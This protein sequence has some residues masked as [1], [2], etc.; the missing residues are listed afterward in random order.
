V[1]RRIAHGKCES[2]EEFQMKFCSVCKRHK[3]CG[4]ADTRTTPVEFKC[5]GQPEVVVEPMM[6]IRTCKCY[7]LKDCLFL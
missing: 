5:P 4:P 6:M 7:R 1:P 2:I 3:C